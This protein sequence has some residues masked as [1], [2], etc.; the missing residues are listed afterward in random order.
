MNR[1]S[2]AYGTGRGRT[3]EIAL[4]IGE[5]LTC[6]GRNVDARPGGR[7]WCARA[8]TTLVM[9]QPVRFRT[10][11]KGWDPSSLAARRPARAFEDD[12]QQW[13]DIRSWAHTLAIELTDQSTPA[14]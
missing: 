9:P 7:V 14:A 2:V 10:P 6:A 4:A 1:I 3:G 5:Q 11:S 12:E 8:H 13:G